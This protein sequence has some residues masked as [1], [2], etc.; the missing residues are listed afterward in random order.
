MTALT[1]LSVSY[2]GITFDKAGPYYLQEVDGLFGA[3]DFI[4][5]DV[6]RAG[7]HGSLLTPQRRGVRLVTLSGVCLDKATRD[8]LFWDLRTAMAPTVNPLRTD[9]VT[10]TTAGVILS[11]YAQPP[12]FQPTQELGKWSRGLWTFAVQWR[13]PDPYLYGPSMRQVIEFSLPPTGITY[14]VTYPVTYPEHPPQGSTII[15]NAG[16][17][18]AAARYALAG[19]WVLPG[20]V[21]VTTGKRVQYGFDLALG[22]E[23]VIDTAQ[24]ASFLNGEYRTPTATSDLT[25]DLAILPGNCTLQALGQGPSWDDLFSLDSPSDGVAVS[26]AFRPAYW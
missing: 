2:R 5:D 8:Q 18:P 1:P 16:T 26:V 21:N 9:E 14:P 23:L 19:P 3:P 11:G 17:A 10:V 20:L 4:L 25:S 22:D 13:M 7:G 12:K 6:P 24:G 15:Y